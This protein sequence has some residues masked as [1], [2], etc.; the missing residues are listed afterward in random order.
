[1]IYYRDVPIIKRSQYQFLLSMI[2]GGI[3]MGF[4][5]LAYAGPPRTPT[6]T[7]RATGMAF[8]FTLVFGS[9]MVKSLRVY[10]VF[11]KSAMKRVVLS[12]VTM[13]KILFVFLLIDSLLLA[14][15]FTVDPV[16]ATSVPKRTATSSGVVTVDIQ[17]C[18]S[19]SFIFSALLIFWKAIL[20]FAGLYLS[21]L[22]R[23]VSTD[24]QESTWIFSS[25][26]AVLFSSVIMLGL[27]YLVEL[28]PTAFYL[29]FA[30]ML[31]SSTTIVMSLM[32]VPKL[33]RHR[34]NVSQ[35]KSTEMSSSGDSSSSNVKGMK[36]VMP[37]SG[38]TKGPVSGKSKNRFS[39]MNRQAPKVSAPSRVQVTPVHQFSGKSNASSK[40]SGVSASSKRHQSSAADK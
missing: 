24:F 30:F 31:L 6:C 12:A 22:I 5:V 32:L 17:M 35:L 11:M 15:W 19:S 20:L 13:F 28:T 37:T 7:C 29:F 23:K 26:L 40:H 16:V 9:L 1:V 25:S 10:R 38:P 8:S 18:R 4:T 33:L 2:V 14:V 34:E 39:F 3:L 21:F 27:A 36:G